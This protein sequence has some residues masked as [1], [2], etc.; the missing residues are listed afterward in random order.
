[1]QRR[2]WRKNWKTREKILAWQ[3]TKVRNQK[4]G[5][6]ARNNGRKVHFKSLMHLCHLKNSEAKYKDGVVLRGDTVNDD[7]GSY[8]VFTEQGS[9]TSQMTAAKV[10]DTISRLPGCAG[11][12]ADA[13]SA[14][15]QVKMEDSPTLL[16][17]PKSECP[18]S[19]FTATKAQMAKNHD[20]NHGP[21]WKT[22]SFVLNEI[23]TVILWQDHYGKGKSRKFL[24][25]YN[26]EK[27]SKLGLLIR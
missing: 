11:Q 19:M 21:V 1:M 3:L 18:D 23:C 10:I 27:V 13:V 16:R 15:T 5:E 12:A 8:V 4:R 25:T 20:Q 24:L 2:Q 14:D 7:F 22:Q 17:I 6:E 26:W 9:S